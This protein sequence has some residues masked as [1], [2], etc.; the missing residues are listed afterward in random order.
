MS[1]KKMSQLNNQTGKEVINA[2][3][4]LTSCTIPQVQEVFLALEQIVFTVNDSNY[5][6]N[7]SV[8]IPYLGKIYFETKKGRK[9]GTTYMVGGFSKE[10][11]RETRI[12]EEDEPDSLRLVFKFFPK[13]QADIKEKSI[14]R[15]LK[16]KW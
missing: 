16:K 12:V 1:R 10:I 8:T 5:S 7:I 2:I 14:K 4:K 9:A 11:K 13:L 15:F 3:S 6:D